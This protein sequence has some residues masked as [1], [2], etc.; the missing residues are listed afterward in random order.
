MGSSLSSNTQTI[1]PEALIKSAV[2]CRVLKIF[3]FYRCT[4]RPC[5][6]S[7]FL[8]SWIV[9]QEVGHCYWGTLGTTKCEN[10]RTCESVMTHSQSSVT[11]LQRQNIRWCLCCESFLRPF[12]LQSIDFWLRPYSMCSTY[13]LEILFGVFF[14]PWAGLHLFCIWW[15]LLLIHLCIYI[16]K[17][18]KDNFEIFLITVSKR[19]A[20]RNTSSIF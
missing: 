11:G 9:L 1:T 16:L 6:Y 15:P 8:V 17:G 2:H 19:S 10:C 5:L 7:Y 20:V 14:H 12:E 3:S 4:G 18:S 13:L